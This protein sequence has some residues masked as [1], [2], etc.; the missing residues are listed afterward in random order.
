M[1]PSRYRLDPILP[2]LFVPVKFRFIPA[3]LCVSLF[4]SCGSSKTAGKIN[5]PLKGLAKMNKNDLLNFKFRD[6][7]TNTPPIV[8]VRHEDLK[9][10]M[11]GKERYLAY[12]QEKELYYIASSEGIEYL[13]QDFD[14]NNLP[15][16]SDL[17]NLG[18]LPP[19]APGVSTAI[20]VD[21]DLGELAP[22][23]S[24]TSPAEE[25]E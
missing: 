20:D 11:T 14:P 21:R 23:D 16:D 12:H 4:T 17:P 7:R 15:A 24:P 3:L 22:P 2:K 1:T 9:E 10:M 8:K 6:L 13:P 19:I 18:I 5:N 25:S